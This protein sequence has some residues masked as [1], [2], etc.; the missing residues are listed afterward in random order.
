[1]GRGR[2]LANT[3]ATPE[4]GVPRTEIAMAHFTS[5]HHS[6]VLQP[7]NTDFELLPL[8]D[9]P[10]PAPV[11]AAND[12]AGPG[13]YESSQDLRRGLTV[14]ESPCDEAELRQWLRACLSA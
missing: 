4:F 7:L 12:A 3:S 8:A 5:P 2:R 1:M 9:A 10:L 11:E 14:R 6:L 13:W